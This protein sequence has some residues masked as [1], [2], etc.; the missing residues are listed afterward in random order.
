MAL[1]EM[2]TVSPYASPFGVCLRYHQR[3]RRL[4]EPSSHTIWA[5]QIINFNKALLFR[6][7][8]A[9]KADSRGQLEVGLLLVWWLVC[10]SRAG[11]ILM[12]PQR[13]AA[14][15]QFTCNTDSRGLRRHRQ[16]RCKISYKTSVREGS[17]EVGRSWNKDWTLRSDV[18]DYL[19]SVRFVHCRCASICSYMRNLPKLK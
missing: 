13:I 1:Y 4:P 3:C 11:R 16:R 18:L 8:G 19:A 6:V 7:R 14:V 17:K 15:V 12:L 9:G 10:L 2:G 5:Q